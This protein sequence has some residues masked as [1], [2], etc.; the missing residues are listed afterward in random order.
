[1]GDVLT[2]IEK[3]ERTID[4]KKARELEQRL[5]KSSF[6]FDDFLE[7][8][9]QVR[10]MGSISS[11]LGMIPGI[12][13][14]KLKGMQ[15]DEKAFDKIQAVIFSMTPEE[16]GHP[17][18]ISGSRRRRIAAGSGTDIHT[19]NQ[20]LTQFKQVQKMMKQLGSGRVPKNPFQMFGNSS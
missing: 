7:Q 11:I 15:V 17:E 2:L 3:A 19:I 18:L 10:K 1:M 16:R 8:I 5:R 6:T 14:G 12:P 13:S 9:Q 20:L 4:E